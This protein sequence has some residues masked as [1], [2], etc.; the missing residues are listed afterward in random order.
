MQP[1]AGLVHARRVLR[2]RR[3]ARPVPAP[4]RCA[5]SRGSTAAGRSRAPRSTW[6]CARPGSSLAEAL[7][8]EPRPV[9][10][11]VSLRLG[12]PADDRAG[13]PAARALPDAALQARPDQRVDRR[14]DRRAG[15]DG[16]V[17]SV[18]FKGFYKGTV[19]DQPADPDLYRRVV[20]AFPGRL[21]RGPGAHR[22][23]ATRCS[24]RTSDRITWDAP[25]HSIAD[26]EALPF[27]P[28]MVNVKPSR[29]GGAARAARRLR[30]PRRARHRRLRRRPVRARARARPD[31]VPGVAVPP[32]H[33]ERRRADRLQRS[34][35]RRRAA[36]RA[37]SQPRPSRPAFAGA[38][39][40]SG[41]QRRR[42][43]LT[44]RADWY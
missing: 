36:R 38:R 12:E 33:A 7:G 13:A 31:P 34:R 16:A 40:P 1:L 39:A 26:I 41:E 25:I 8:R 23:D 44:R 18:D 43:P 3:R 14:A 24:S 21:D 27:P 6:R 20:E 2:A 11:V 35:T 30:L 9:T 10:F 28:K 15:R 4:S 29:F 42:F 37:R 17:D 22:R 5:R 19:V 32:G